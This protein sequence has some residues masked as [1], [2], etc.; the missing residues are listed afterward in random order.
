[1]VKRLRLIEIHEQAWCPSFIRRMVLFFL[2][3]NWTGSLP[4]L[5]PPPFT[6]L[7]PAFRELV[8]MCAGPQ[9]KVIDLCSGYSGPV[10]SLMREL[11]KSTAKPISV[12]LTDL[13]PETSHWKVL[14]SVVGAQK[15]SFIPTSVDAT[16]PQGLEGIRTLFSSIHHFEPPQVRSIFESA[17]KDRQPIFIAELQTR[18]LTGILKCI[19]GVA[20]GSII[21]TFFCKPFSILRL[22]FFVLFPITP[23]VILVDAIVSCLR[24]YTNKELAS[25]VATIEG[26]DTF[27]WDYGEKPM[28]RGADAVTWFIGHPKQ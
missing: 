1:M 25:I 27:T 9:V 13:F 6:A 4:G 10:V 5:P 11:A 17:I 21:A 15:L 7:I 26:S 20:S 22:I 18:T 16:K 24:T 2:C 8:E 14:Q 19:P 28:D 12:V 3:E 23:L